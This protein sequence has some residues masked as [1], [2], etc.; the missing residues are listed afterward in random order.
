MPEQ[1]AVEEGRGR[2]LLVV[3]LAIILVGALLGL[4]ASLLL[5]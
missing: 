2:G 1:S 4:L 3:L 5:T